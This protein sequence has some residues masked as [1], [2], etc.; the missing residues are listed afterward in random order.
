MSKKTDNQ[1][2]V[3]V[4]EPRRWMVS[5]TLNNDQPVR[6]TIIGDQPLFF[7]DC[8]TDEF[9]DDMMIESDPLFASLNALE[10][11]LENLLES[12]TIAGEAHTGLIAP[13]ISPLCDDFAASMKKLTCGKTTT[14]DLGALIDTLRQSR[15]AAA[16]LNFAAQH[17]I[18][19]VAGTAIE[20]AQYDRAA[21]KIFLN[22][23]L[24]ETDLILL[25][26]RELRRVWQHKHGALLHPMTFHPDQAILIN[27]SQQADLATAM[28]RGA[29]ELQLAGVKAPWERL[30]S[31]SFND[32]CRAFARE[33]Y[34][35]FRALNNG[36]ASSAVFESWFLSERCRHADRV[37]IQDMLS[38]YQ[39][40]VFGSEQASRPVTIDLIMAL[41]SVPYGKNYLAPYISTI[42][43]EALFTEVRDR[44]NA[45]FLWFIKFE[46]SFREAEQELQKGNVVTDR[47]NRFDPPQRKKEGDDEERSDIIHLPTGGGRSASALQERQSAEGG[48]R[49]L[50]FQQRSKQ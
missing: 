50:P 9:A 8:E 15:L 49:I 22:A 26:L 37:L 27:R 44:S 11:G 30:E 16:Y 35:D 5:Y 43:K 38:D 47:G 34:Q 40:Y 41:G 39:G 4:K 3:S 36:S 28:V 19:I 14:C 42:V 1:K 46:R 24:D 21:G 29:W 2:N 33:A 25:C 32:L 17:N 18:S 31:T 48:A 7:M 45:N 23:A 6:C 20:T 10:T 12:Y 13:E